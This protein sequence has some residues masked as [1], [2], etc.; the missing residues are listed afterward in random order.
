MKRKGRDFERGILSR[1]I[2][3][4][5]SMTEAF[6][7]AEVWAILGNLAGHHRLPH[8]KLLIFDDRYVEIEEVV[9]VSTRGSNGGIGKREAE[10]HE[11]IS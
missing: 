10:D 1:S 7:E 2:A 9:L 11:I 8:V 6:R 4:A 5:R 3:S